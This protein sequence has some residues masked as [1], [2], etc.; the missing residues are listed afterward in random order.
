MPRS[1]LPSPKSML[2]EREIAVL[3]EHERCQKLRSSMV[4]WARNC[5]YEPALH[6]RLLLSALERAARKKNARIIVCMPPGS[7]KSVYISKL[8]PGW[9]LAQ[10]PRKSILACSYAKDLIQGF[11]RA[12]REWI[13]LK[14]KD[15]K[16]TLK[17]DTKAADEW[18]TTNG[19]RYFCAGTNAGIAG[20][21]ADLAF[22]DDPIGSDEDAQ[23]QTYRDK[24]WTWFW[25]DFRPR[26]SNPGSSIIIIANRRHEDDLVGR[27]LAT[28]ANDWEL[29][30]MP[31][32][33]DTPLQEANDALGRKIGDILWPEH[34]TPLTV[35]DARK[36]KNFS[37][38]Y[39]QDP[40]P[41]EGD[42][43]KVDHLVEYHS[44]EQIPKNIREYVGSD[45][46]LTTKEENDSNCL[47]PAALDENGELWIL[48]DVFW[49]Q[50]NTA[51]LVEEMLALNKRHNLAQWFAENEH[52]HKAIGPFLEKRMMATKNFIPMVPMTS[53]KDLVARS[54]S[55]R[56]MMSLRKVHFPAFAPWWH[57]AKHQM[58]SFP[59]GKHDDFLA[60]LSEIGR[61]LNEMVAPT[62]PKPDW[63]RETAGPTPIFNL[64]WLKSSHRRKTQRCRYA[65]R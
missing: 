63:F 8:F 1:K 42:L 36:S 51:Q 62:P 18:E 19:G 44:V 35:R 24:Q 50:C 37:G 41:E 33:I 38:L 49:G 59:K 17:S 25:D 4:E 12:A 27:L 54:A 31:L 60:A 10:E 39:Q 29:I 30:K 55:V 2:T 56:G 14:G 11:G 23:S 58:L 61:G 65:G 34:F 52:I 20:H 28:E 6:H 21:R 57:A 15:L 43:I 53:S 9:F 5:G 3:K 22:I 46:A 40:S 48:P 16:L 64:E 32:V 47:I 45:H 7:A 26:A 13:K